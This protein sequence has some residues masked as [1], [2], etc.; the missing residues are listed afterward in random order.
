MDYSLAVS[1]SEWEKLNSTYE[2]YREIE[3][4]SSRRDSLHSM[5]ICHMINWNVKVF[6]L[7]Y[8]DTIVYLP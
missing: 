5:R 1:S 6:I 4:Y 7:D 2:H 8:R 3:M